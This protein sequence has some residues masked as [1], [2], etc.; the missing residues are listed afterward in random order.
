MKTIYPSKKI[1]LSKSKI[2]NAGRGVFA[3]QDIAKNDII[4]ICP[5]LE[6][7]ANDVFNLKESIFVNYY[8]S[9]DDDKDMLAIALGFGS[10]YNHSYEP[11]TTYKKISKDNVLEFRAIKDIKRGEEITVNYNYGDPNDKSQLWKDIPPFEGGK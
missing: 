1:Y 3:S 4:E 6:V 5:I 8:F 9:F 2:K 7:P 11:N 10:I